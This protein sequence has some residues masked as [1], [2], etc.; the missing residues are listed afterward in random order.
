MPFDCGVPCPPFCDSK[1]CTDGSR[2]YSVKPLGH[3]ISYRVLNTNSSEPDAQWINVTQAG[4]ATTARLQSLAPG[5][6]YEVK[7][8]AM[9]AA[10][11][12]EWSE[13]TIIQTNGQPG[14]A[15]F[16]DDEPC[17]GERGSGVVEV[18]YSHFG[19]DCYGTPTERRDARRR[20]LLVGYCE[21]D[22]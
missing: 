9:N 6:S 17:G 5:F 10:G 11:N 12:G 19:T 3:E 4:T 7:V 8:R 2:H 13:P 20:Q 18:S 22:E 1:V 14:P 21:C 16:Q 15:C